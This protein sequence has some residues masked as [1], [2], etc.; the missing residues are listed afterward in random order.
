MTRF[1]VIQDY[2]VLPTTLAQW[3]LDYRADDVKFD[4]DLKARTVDRVDATH[5]HLVNDMVRGKRAIHLDGIVTINGPVDWS[6]ECEIS[7]EG[8]PFAHESNSFHV[9]PVGASGCRLTAVFVWRPKSFLARLAL[10]LIKGSLRRE[11]E[12]VYAGYVSSLPSGGAP[13]VSPGGP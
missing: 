11:R 12:R 9:E 4:P 8:R 6:Y 1:T 3:W 5:I 10:P 2:P 7:L 13:A